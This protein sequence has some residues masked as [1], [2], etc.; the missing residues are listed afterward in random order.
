MTPGSRRNALLWRIVRLETASSRLEGMF[1][2][3]PELA[4]MWRAG[5]ALSE[6]CRS[7]S[8]EDIS[9]FEG[10]VIRRPLE[11]LQ[12]EQEQAR[13]TIAAHHLLRVMTAP[14]DLLN[15]AAA[16]VTRCWTAA[17]SV[18]SGEA[19][20]DLGEIAGRIA[21]DLP[22]AP[23]PFLGALRSAIL[24]RLMTEGRA[25]SADRL[26]FMA[27]EHGLRG[28]GGPDRGLP[29][30]PE[31]M[32]GGIAANWTLTPSVALTQNRFRAWSP[33]SPLGVG[34]LIAGLMEC[35]HHALGQLPVMRHWRAEARRRS[36]AKHGKSRLRD[37]VDLAIRQ[38]ILTSAKCRQELGVSERASYYLMEE[39]A[40]EGILTLITPR[41]SYRV[42]ATPHMAD[43]L[44]MRSSPV[45]GRGRRGLRQ[46]EQGRGDASEQPLPDGRD[47]ALEK[48]QFADSSAK[49]M[50]DL[51][52]ALASA[53][54][55]LE[56]Y[57]RPEE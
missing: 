38:P 46:A 54:S 44:R 45:K 35:N 47:G 18:E 5:A 8:M 26:I 7:V 34:E 20:L 3:D 32:L 28:A 29:A 9:I 17:V 56:K 16:V 4:M 48:D 14:G 49:A 21:R 13:G 52:A 27:A 2:A 15:D 24:F 10:D 57:R 36:G 12:I 6:A 55:I 42:W 22:D 23:S 40:T 53:D 19:V 33:V 31:E 25:P 1:L 37:L 51:D 39:A 41:S 50:A 30:A 43:L 11:N